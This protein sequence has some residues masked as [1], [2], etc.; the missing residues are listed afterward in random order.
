MLITIINNISCLVCCCIGSNLKMSGNDNRENRSIHNTKPVDTLDLK[1][2]VNH[3]AHSCSSHGV[4]CRS[5]EL[6]DSIVCH[7]ACIMYL[8]KASSNT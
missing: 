5:S 1:V 3:L 8:P 2:G 7:R 4:E 6:L